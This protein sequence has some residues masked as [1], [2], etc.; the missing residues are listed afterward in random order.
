MDP[1][2]GMCS[3]VKS[4]NIPGFLIK[5][6]ALVSNP[7]TDEL[8]CWSPSGNSFQVFNTDQFTKELLP[9]Y[10]KH[11]KMASF[12]RQLNKYGFRKVAHIEQQGLVKPQQD[13]SEFQHPYFQRDQEQLLERINSRVVSTPTVKSKDGATKLWTDVQLLKQKQES[14][15]AEL[16]SM[17]QGNQ[18]LCQEVDSLKQ[19]YTQQQKAVNKVIQFLMPLVQSKQGKGLKRK[20]PPGVDD[21]TSAPSAPKHSPPP[22]PAYSSSSLCAQDAVNSSGA[23]VWDIPEH[24]PTSPLTS[25]GNSRNEKSLPSGPQIPVK[26]GPLSPPQSPCVEEV[27]AGLLSSMDSSASLTDL[28]DSILRDSDSTLVPSTGCTPTSPLPSTPE[29]CLDTTSLNKDELCDHPNDMDCSLDDLKTMLTSHSLDMDTLLD[30]FSP[31]VTMPDMSLPD[32]DSSLASILS[33]QESPRPTEVEN[34]SP[35]PGKQPVKYTTPPMDT[36][37]KLL[38]LSKLAEDSCV[39]EPIVSLLMGNELLKAKDLTMS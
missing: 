5:L 30:L 33:P 27:N 15:N 39:E 17:K 3:P 37:S 10:F 13:A 23:T 31:S 9:R 35:D 34:G 14:M 7:D 1:P 24:T 29:K 16:L 12:V 18:A 8:I 4:N 11:N 20:R 28:I 25:P 38:T 19:K 6:W 36:G 32:Q 22:T 2:V 21:S 26:E